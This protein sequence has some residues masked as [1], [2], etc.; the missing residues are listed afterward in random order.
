MIALLKSLLGVFDRTSRFTP[1]KSSKIENSSV[2]RRYRQNHIGNNL[3]DFEAY[4]TRFL[5]LITFVPI[6]LPGN[7]GIHLKEKIEKW[8]HIQKP[9]M[10][11]IFEN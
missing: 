6:K 11:R 3:N 4:F 1:L 10:K 2:R 5:D 9:V 8:I 7:T